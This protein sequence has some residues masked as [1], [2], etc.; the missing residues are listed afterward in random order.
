M[1]ISD[2]IVNYSLMTIEKYS[3]NYSDDYHHRVTS[4]H[5]LKIF[6]FLLNKN[7]ICYEEKKKNEI[8]INSGHRLSTRKN[9]DYS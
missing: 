2:P 3:Y 9:R 8:Q 6:P 7:S 4:S 5:E 1:N